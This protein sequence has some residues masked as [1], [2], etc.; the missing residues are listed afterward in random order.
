[1]KK[2]FER[3]WRLALPYL[4]KGKRKDFVIHTKGVIK[5]MELLLRR[6]GGDKNI[7]IPVAIVHDVGWSRV[8]L[9]LQR[10]N[11]KIERKRA[12]KLHL[13]YAPPIIEKILT[14]CGYDKN[15][16]KKII[17]IVLSHMFKNPRR[18]DKRLLIDADTLS[19]TFKEEFYIN[20]KAYKTT[21]EEHY[22]FRK[23][24]RF[25]TKTAKMIFHIEIEKRRK[26][27]F[28]TT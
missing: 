8:P 23:N 21:P 18:L 1:M 26:E 22:N 4:K 9:N 16:I 6:E 24:N 12:L 3:V 20:V 11:K 7:L 17:D 27:I 10:S 14:K 28:K 5:A 19:E 15:Q 2:K 25:Y 13:K